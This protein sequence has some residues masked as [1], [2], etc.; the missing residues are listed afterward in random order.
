M[1]PVI[2]SFPRVNTADAPFL[3]PA[4]ITLDWPLPPSNN[5]LNRTARGSYYPTAAYKR[6]REAA[7]ALSLAQMPKG[8]F[9]RIN[10]AYELL[11]VIDRRKLRANADLGNREKAVSD[12]LQRS[13]FIEND[14]LAVRIVQE[15]GVAPEGA[16]ITIR[17]MG[18]HNG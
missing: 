3:P 11:I 9:Q 10:G 6:W 15:F 13:G 8:G 5:N 16:R 1:K 4:Q 12:N 2:G 14:K 18:E 17:S 7:D